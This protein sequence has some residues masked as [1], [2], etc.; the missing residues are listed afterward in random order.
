MA[1]KLFN[2]FNRSSLIS[3]R[4]ALA[5]VNKTDTDEREKILDAKRGRVNEG[6]KEAFFSA[7][8]ELDF[9]PYVTQF[10]ARWNKGPQENN[11]KIVLKNARVVYTSELLIG[12][13]FLLL[14]WSLFPPFILRL[15][16]KGRQK[17]QSFPLLDFPPRFVSSKSLSK[18][19]KFHPSPKIFLAFF[20]PKLETECPERQGQ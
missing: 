12:G 20:M 14:F 19:A 17:S 6:K 8:R 4:K 1:Q 2:F 3:L 5:K 16:S 9:T 13:K 18:F 11:G 10:P 15:F 7:M